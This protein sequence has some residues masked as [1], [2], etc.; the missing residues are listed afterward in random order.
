MA[1]IN[2]ILEAAIYASDIDVAERFY[3][4]L[5]GFRTYAKAENRHVFFKIGDTMLLIFNPEETLQEGSVPGH[6]SKGPGHVAFTIT[7]DALPLWRQRLQQ[8]GVPI[9]HEMTWPSGGKSIYFRDPDN[10]SVELATAD[11]WP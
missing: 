8:Y 9:E 6:G 10:N 5:L 4:Q 11:V 2:Q 3:T 1:E 7:H